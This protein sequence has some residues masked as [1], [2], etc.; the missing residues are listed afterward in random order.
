MRLRKDEQVQVTVT[1]RLASDGR[2]EAAPTSAI[3][4]QP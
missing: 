3:G 2:V 4:T 1:G